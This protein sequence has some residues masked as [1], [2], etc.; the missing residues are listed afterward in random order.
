M[1]RIKHTLSLLSLLFFLF[2]ISNGVAQKKNLPEFT[3]PVVKGNIPDLKGLTST[4]AETRGDHF[5]NGIDISSLN[6]SVSPVSPGKIL[7][8]R[9]QND[10]P[11]KP[12][13]GPG[14]YIFIDHGNGWWSGYYHLDRLSDLREGSVRKDDIIGFT[15]NTGHSSGAHLHFFILKNYGEVYLNPLSFLPGITDSNPPVIGQIEIVTP[16]GKT[17]IS[18]SRPQEI[19][20]TKSYPLLLQ[21]TDAG[22]EKN[23]RRGIFSLEWQL[24]QMSPQKLTFDELRLSEKGWISPQGKS[25]EETYLHDLYNLGELPLINGSNKLKITAQDINGLSTSVIFDINVAKEF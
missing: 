3:W 5:H 9:L 20:L 10:D 11:Y 15:G 18:H 17:L 13:P 6:D 21:V 16:S 19:R 1:G 8:S 12:Q 22:M 4:F 24:N 23:T 2:G 25:F 14:N 7:Y